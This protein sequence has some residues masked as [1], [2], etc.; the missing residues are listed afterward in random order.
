[1]ATSLI[2]KFVFHYEADIYEWPLYLT[3]G[4][5][6]VPLI[7]ELL[8]KALRG[9][10]G[11]D[12]LAGIS[13]IT[14]I[15]LGE[16]L[17][18]S[19]V[20]L[21][22]SG[23]E[24]LENYAVS[25]ASSVLDTLARRMPSIAHRRQAGLEEGKLEDIKLSEI[26]VGDI[27]VIFPHDTAPVDGTVIEG[28]GVMDEAYLTGESFEVSKS[29]GSEVISGAING[30]SAITIRATR[31]ADESRYAKIMAVMRDTAH[32]KVALK[33]LGDQL[34]AWYTPLALVIAI[35]AWLVS[36]DPIR[37]LSV[38]VIATPCPL[39][40][41]I[42][43][44]IIGS[45]SLA[46][47]RGII[48]KDPAILERVD[49]CRTIILDKTGTLTYGTP[50]LAEEY[51]FNNFKRETVLRLAAG[52]ERYSKHPL[53]APLL[54]TARKANL[55]I[56]DAERLSEK[57]GEGLTGTID[58][59]VIHITGRKALI[60]KGNPEVEKLPPTS[61][62]LEC[63]VIIN[64]LLAGLFNFRDEPRFES[65]SF[66]SHLGPKHRFKKIMILSGDRE[67]EVRYLADKVGI[68]E[69]YASKSPEEKLEIVKAETK[70][71][72]TLYLGDGIND[73]PS[74]M[75]A[76][77]GIALGSKSDVTSEA[78]GAVIM[79]ASLIKVDEFFHIAQRM[80]SIA[81]QSAVGGMAL[82]VVGMLMAA[83]GLLS[84][85][86]GA[87]GQEFIDL[88]AVINALR[89]SIVPRQLTDFD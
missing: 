79:D 44:A 80:R 62:G 65:H 54:E 86:A 85:V 46:A 20:V 6:G 16:Y 34:G 35:I 74:L 70:Q 12:L 76:T 63:V 42:P 64:G 53:S 38:L 18:G 77:V 75:A 9:Q 5:G 17:A 59:F 23:G 14:S 56:K 33:R 39:L 7:Y 41:A 57:P 60:A 24:A 87:L 30:D 26:N 36:N 83:S 3:L 25:R 61:G 88:L 27:L 32:K 71:A 82:S 55:E 45:I 13:I 69:I 72:S 89:V 8:L 78:A 52:L 43:V 37:F 10:F 58:G 2:L 84:P 68:K 28:R 73:A 49:T 40:I 22:L 19:L 47:K 11:S 51:Y 66:I 1:M 21:M 81:L 15:V 31:K 50:T 4:L 48:V 67:S 29:T